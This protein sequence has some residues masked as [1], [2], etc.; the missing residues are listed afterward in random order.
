MS[1]YT[2]CPICDAPINLDE[3]GCHTGITLHA[4]QYVSPPYSSITGKPIIGEA[5]VEFDSAG[6]EYGTVTMSYR[7]LI[8][9]TGAL[10]RKAGGT[11]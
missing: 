6:G 4:P 2:P 7:E 3:Y 9:L 10:Y 5:Y 8:D 11:P 1:H